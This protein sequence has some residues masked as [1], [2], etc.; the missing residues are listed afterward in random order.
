MP[1]VGA[2]QVVGAASIPLLKV[3]KLMPQTPTWFVLEPVE[4]QEEVEGGSYG[5]L[6]A[7]FQIIPY[8]ELDRA[9]TPT[10]TFT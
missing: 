10:L 4:G 5:E 9:S 2:L 6:L 7:S 8:E 3:E 1:V